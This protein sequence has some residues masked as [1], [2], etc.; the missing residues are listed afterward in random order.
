MKWLPEVIQ[1]ESIL[2]QKAGDLARFDGG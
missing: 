2:L 1:N